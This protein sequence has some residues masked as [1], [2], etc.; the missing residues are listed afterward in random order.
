M[1]NIIKPNDWARVSGIVW[2]QTCRSGWKGLYDILKSMITRRPLY[3][4]AEK[5]E[6]SMWAKSDVPCFF[7]VNDVQLEY[8]KA[9]RNATSAIY[10]SQAYASATAKENK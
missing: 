5:F 3:T 4:M 2:A 8:N 1:N 9:K 10:Y 6:I 7:E